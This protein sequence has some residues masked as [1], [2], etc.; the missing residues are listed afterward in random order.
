MRYISFK[1]LIM[2]ILLPPILYLLTVSS[3]EDY[4]HKKYEREIT[5]IYLS[6]M[7]DILNGLITIKDAIDAS[8][9]PYLLENIFIKTGGKIDVNVTTKQGN[10]LY[11]AT[12]QNSLFENLSTDPS[13]IAEKNFKILNEGIEINVNV[14]ILH[15]SFIAFALLFFYIM[16]FLSVLYRYYRK[17]SAKIH[18]DELIQEKEL[19]RLHELEKKR[20]QEIDTLSEERELLLSEFDQLKSTF[21]IEKTQAEK[22]EEDLFDE[23]ETLESKLKEI[24]RLK[25]KIQSLEKSQHHITR[26]KDKTIEKLKKRFKTLYKNIGISNRALANLS[27]MS[28]EM[29]LKAEEVINQLDTNSL[30]VPVKRKVF[31]KKG[32]TTSFEVVFAYNGRLYFHKLKNN[33]IEILTIGSKN[34]QQKDMAF[35]DNL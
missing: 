28:E 25:E 19:E 12:Y 34:T 31:S 23:I 11:P 21:K 27:D 3:L 35:I 6:D 16:T 9:T 8:V 13:K 26:Q 5:N 33:R 1:I 24:D 32:K 2:C 18:L 10:I 20:L 29:S 7:N 30:N 22:T 4:L 17:F 14:K 15:Y